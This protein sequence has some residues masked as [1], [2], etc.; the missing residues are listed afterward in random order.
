[1]SVP[2]PQ[3]FFDIQLAF[4]RKMAQLSGQPYHEAILHQTA[5]YRILGLDWSLDP[6][7]PA[8]QQFLAALGPEAADSAVYRF[9]SERVAQGLIPE[10]DTSRPHWG[11]FSY[12]WLAELKAA[13]LHFSSRD[14]SGYGP[15]SHQRQQVRLDELQAMFRHIRQE[16]PDAERVRGGT[17]LYNRPEYCRLF[18]PEYGASAQVYPPHLI[19][20]GLWGQFLRHGNRMNEEVTAR[21]LE[22]IGCLQT[23]EAHASCFPYQIL[24]TEAPITLFYAFYGL[25]A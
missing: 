9:Y 15:L 12:E 22:N 6:Q 5:L 19:A 14:T 4:A 2:Y 20:R 7:N 13:R 8:W 17:W 1:M 18:P 24:V 3:A 25:D 10:Y 16:Q 11:C 23:V 21:F